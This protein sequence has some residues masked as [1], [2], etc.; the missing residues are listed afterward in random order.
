MIS[1]LS[2]TSSA[3][4]H[5]PGGSYIFLRLKNI[6][7]VR[8]SLVHV[9]SKSEQQKVKLRFPKSADVCSILHTFLRCAPRLA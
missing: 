9:S 7:D 5:F 3:S 8:S 2:L 1:F 4:Y 6:R